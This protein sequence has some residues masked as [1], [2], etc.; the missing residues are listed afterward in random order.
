MGPKA[1]GMSQVPDNFL[2]LDEK[3]SD[4][5]AARYAVLP[6]PYDATT[7]YASG[8][9][10]GPRAVITASQQVEWFDEELEDEYFEAGIATRDPVE[11]DLNSPERMHQRVFDVAR[12][13]VKDGKFLIGLGGEHSITS[14]LVRAVMTHRRRLSVLQIDAHADLRDSY[15]GT[16][17]SHA[18]VM[19]RVHDLGATLVPV[20]IR[21][22]SQAESRFMKRAGI[23]PITAREC[24]ETDD[25]ID[26]AVEGLA[27]NVYITIDI[28]GFDPAYAPGTGTPEP[29]GLGYYQV[30]DLLR[31]VTEA[32]NVL[33]ADIVEIKPVPGQTVTEFLAARLAYKLIAYTQAGNDLSGS[34]GK[35]S[36][37]A[38]GTAD[39]Q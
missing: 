8:T 11:P 10:D 7:C 19:R 38:G 37:D 2:G 15:Q 25:W 36:H 30:V 9:R 12:H 13:I 18:C 20:G 14:G 16:A 6:V 1:V 29:G 24:H 5:G 26:R 4:Y 23:T 34:K 39:Q 21:S 17:Y 35:R 28:D 32:K 22:C 3:Y 31:A 27:D 33:G